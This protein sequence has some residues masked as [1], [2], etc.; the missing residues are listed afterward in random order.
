LISD[1]MRKAT[2]LAKLSERISHLGFA[3]RKISKKSKCD[4]S[5]LNSSANYNQKSTACKRWVALESQ[6]EIL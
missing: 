3:G 6:W 2:S 5:L 1:S 4:C